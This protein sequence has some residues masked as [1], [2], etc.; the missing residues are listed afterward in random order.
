MHTKVEPT[1]HLTIAIHRPHH[2]MQQYMVH[3]N[4]IRHAATMR[5]THMYSSRISMRLAY[6]CSISD[7]P[8]WTKVATKSVSIS[9]WHILLHDVLGY[10]RVVRRAGSIATTLESTKHHS[11]VSHLGPCRSVAGRVGALACTTRLRQVDAPACR[12]RQ[13][14]MP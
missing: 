13:S 1:L 14:Q 5:G 8:P 3:G 12:L 6:F 11:N 7:F 4:L 2:I 10:C 9:L